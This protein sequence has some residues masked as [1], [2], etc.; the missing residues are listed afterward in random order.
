M[1]LKFKLSVLPAFSILL[2]L[3]LL[4]AA[5]AVSAQKS[6]FIGY[7]HRG[8]VYGKT[9]PNGARD[10]GGGLLSDENYGISRFARGRKQMLWLEK[11]TARDKKGVPSWE[12]KDVIVFGKPKKN[13]EFLFSYGSTCTE[14][15]AEDLD[16]IVLAEFEAAQKSYKIL[17]A[18]RADL[19]RE[20][21]TELPVEGIKCEYVEP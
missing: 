20:K 12:V 3:L 15:G 21:F 18:W 11:I 19:L 16:L 13:Q 1:S 4:L 17:R 7:R 14:N 2:S 6:E 5:G 8:V 10:L 9:L